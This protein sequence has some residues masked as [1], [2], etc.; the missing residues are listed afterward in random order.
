[1]K[2]VISNLKKILSNRVEK[3]YVKTF[4]DSISKMNE[5]LCFYIP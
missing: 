1:M 3:V 5:W 2:N 4:D